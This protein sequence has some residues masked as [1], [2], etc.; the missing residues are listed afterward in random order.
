MNARFTATFGGEAPQISDAPSNRPR[1]HRRSV[2]SARVRFSSF[3]T[4]FFVRF[5]R[6]KIISACAVFSHILDSTINFG[7]RER[8]CEFIELYELILET[9]KKISSHLWQ[10]LLTHTREKYLKNKNI[11]IQRVLITY[12]FSQCM[13]RSQISSKKEKYSN[14]Q[15]KRILVVRCCFL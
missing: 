2:R 12:F 7:I 13:L 11:L 9:L 4:L 10:N 6:Y 15:H 8:N 5:D 3:L 1:K 14:V